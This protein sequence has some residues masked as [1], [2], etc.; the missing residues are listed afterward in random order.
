MK[1]II[2]ILFLT[3]SILSCKQNDLSKEFNCKSATNL[4][5][6]K[7]I[8][9]VM[10]KFKLTLPTSWSTKLYYDEFQSEIY[11]ADTT[12]SLTKTLITEVS[13]HQGELNLDKTFDQSVKDTLTRKEQLYPVKS[14]FITFKDKPAY[15]NLAK[16]KYGKHTYHFL[17]VYIKTEVDEYFTFT[18]KIYGNELVDDRL[19]T[20]IELYNKIEFLEK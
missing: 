5:K 8:R 13:W 16:G 12:K 11:S 2:G 17:Q 4:G 3:L 6:T 7:E 10:K 15:W 9:D 18:T 19:C 1:K 20:A 14:N